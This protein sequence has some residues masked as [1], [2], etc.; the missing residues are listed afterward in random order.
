MACS[1]AGFASPHAISPPSKINVNSKVVLIEI[2][3]FNDFMVFS[4]EGI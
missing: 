1:R 4:L 3:V 2:L